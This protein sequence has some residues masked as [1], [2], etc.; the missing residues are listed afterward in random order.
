[1]FA[2]FFPSNYGNFQGSTPFKSRNF[3]RPEVL[4]TFDSSY[5]QETLP[6]TSD[7]AT[8]VDF[9]LN[10]DSSIHLDLQSLELKIEATI[11]K[12]L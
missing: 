12:R 11:K 3:H 5:K 2:K 8:V 4:V 10:T 7:D 1:M 9:L 6:I